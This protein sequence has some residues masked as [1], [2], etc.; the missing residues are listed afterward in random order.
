[1]LRSPS[2]HHT[3]RP[4]CRL[5]AGVEDY[6]RRY[7][8]NIEAVCREQGGPRAMKDTPTAAAIEAA[9]RA[10]VPRDR[11]A[12]RHIRGADSQERRR[13][14][15]ERLAALAVH[16]QAATVRLPLPLPQCSPTPSPQFKTCPSDNARRSHLGMDSP[17]REII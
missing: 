4:H 5:T 7:G 2:H 1:M 6:C 9:Q 12:V 17:R 8:D 15:D 10:T 3:R 14:R 16:K 11:M 13:W